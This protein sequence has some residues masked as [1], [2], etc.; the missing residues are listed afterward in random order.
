MLNDT[1][2]DKNYQTTKYDRAAVFK[3]RQSQ[4]AKVVD[5][6]RGRL[7]STYNLIT[8]NCALLWSAA[9]GAIGNKFHGGIFGPNAKFNQIRNYYW[10]S[11]WLETRYA[12]LSWSN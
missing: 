2:L 3:I 1:R 8:D 10:P 9:L 6:V 12:T 11:H 5:A 4:I 7:N